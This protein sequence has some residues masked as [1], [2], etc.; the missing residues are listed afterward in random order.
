MYCESCG[1]FIPDGQTYCS[2]CGAKAP[3]TTEPG[4]SA[5]TVLPDEPVQAVKIP[6]EP[7]QP[8]YPQSD[9]GTVYNESV[10]IPT[11]KKYIV[12]YI[13]RAGLILGIVS[14]VAVYIP[15]TNIVPAILG[16][17]FSL[18]GL[19]NVDERGGRGNCIA[20]LILSGVGILLFLLTVIFA[21]I[22]NTKG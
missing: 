19:R 9:A 12:N 6:I 5:Q 20:G 10:E 1:S 13:A 17:I 14:V 7:A 3:A 18:L 16:I 4:M 8:I 2:N 15:Y 22:R 11:P 21:I